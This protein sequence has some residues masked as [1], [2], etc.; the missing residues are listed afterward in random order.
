MHG[1]MLKFTQINKYNT[2]CVYYILIEQ[3]V[4]NEKLEQ[5]LI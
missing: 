4:E 5:F 3:L 1:Q 2:L